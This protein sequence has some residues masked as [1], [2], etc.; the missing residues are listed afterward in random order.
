MER[1]RLPLRSL[2]ALVG[3][4]FAGFSLLLT[5]VPVVTDARGLGPSAIGIVLAVV[6]GLGIVVDAP[7]GGWAARPSWAG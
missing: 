2:L 4:N 7:V 6:A 1:E 5:A 3:F